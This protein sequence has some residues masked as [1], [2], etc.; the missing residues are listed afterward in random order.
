MESKI[1]FD[2]KKYENIHPRS[3][4][5][6][7]K[8]EGSKCAESHVRCAESGLI[9][10]LVGA[11]QLS[12]RLGV[13]RGTFVAYGTTPKS[14]CALSTT[15]ASVL[16]WKTRFGFSP[17]VYSRSNTRRSAVSLSWHMQQSIVDRN[18]AVA[19]SN[20]G[21]TSPGG[22]PSWRSTEPAVASLHLCTWY[23]HVYLLFRE[24]SSGL[25]GSPCSIIPAVCYSKHK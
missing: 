9:S 25:T 6:R 22:V 13:K 5:L 1:Q 17:N 18:S 8:Q 15:L 4:G 16:L 11:L 23:G 21:T 24:N 12:H 2:K 7:E 14:T 10:L 3:I 20:L 19:G